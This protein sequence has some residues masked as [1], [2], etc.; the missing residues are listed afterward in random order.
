MSKVKTFWEN[1][2]VYYGPEWDQDPPKEET[3]LEIHAD[4]VKE[5]KKCDLCNEPCNNDWCCEKDET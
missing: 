4:G 1:M 5:V 3:E 2:H